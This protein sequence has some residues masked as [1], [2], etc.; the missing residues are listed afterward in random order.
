M[1]T[2]FFHLRYYQRCYSSFNFLFLR[3]ILCSAII[4]LKSMGFSE[5][6]PRNYTNSVSVF[7]CATPLA[8]KTFLFL[9]TTFKH[10]INQFH[11]TSSPPPPVNLQVILPGIILGGERR[12]PTAGAEGPGCLTGNLCHRQSASG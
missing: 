9:C 2:L 10:Q 5:F 3:K 12:P 6:T 1:F 8:A 11:V 4:P 7:L